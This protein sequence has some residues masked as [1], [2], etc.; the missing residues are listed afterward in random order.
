MAGQQ[1]KDIVHLYQEFGGRP[2]SYQELTRTRAAEQARER[3]PLISRLEELPP[4][5]AVPPVRPD[6]P[7]GDAQLDWRAAPVPALRPPQERVEPG[8]P[9]PALG[10][11]PVPAACDAPRLA[12]A[13]A[14]LPWLP[15]GPSGAAPAPKP[16]QPPLPSPSPSPAPAPAPA[17]AALPWAR[18]E[19][20]PP[21]RSVPPSGPAPAPARHRQDAAAPQPTPSPLF[22]PPEPQAQE[23]AAARPAAGQAATNPLF[24][25][26]PAAARQAPAA[27]PA[28]PAPPARPWQAP[29][30]GPAATARPE[31]TPAPASSSGFDPASQPSGLRGASPLAR[32]AQRVAQPAPDTRPAGLQSFFARLTGH[33]RP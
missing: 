29:E 24:A 4:G 10:A 15:H 9:W 19:S 23:P 33:E 32:L 20:P 7:A 30:P 16:P 13:P 26:P 1:P 28:P 25:S 22:R 2:D 18:S 6:E 14:P 8:G 17:P 31:A 3:W 12:A 11:G 21:H 5:A 27:R